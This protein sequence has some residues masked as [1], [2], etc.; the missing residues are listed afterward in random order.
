[1]ANKGT[2]CVIAAL[3]S[4]MALPTRADPGYYL[5]SVYENEGQASVDFRY[6]T[7]KTPGGGETVWPEIGIGYGVTKRWYTEVYASMIGPHYG[8]VRLSTLNWQ[9]D[10]LLTQGQYPFDLALHTNLILNPGSNAGQ[11]LEFG[12][13]LQTEVGRI[14]INTNLIFERFFNTPAPAPTQ[15]K[16]QWQFKYRF[17]PELQM[18]LQGFGELGTWNDWA[19]ADRQSHRAGP[20]VAGTLFQKGSSA[21]KYDA[22]V[23]LGSTYGRQGVMFS[24]RLQYLF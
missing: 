4:C 3:A 12:P 24:S 17:R 11:S 2:W 5:V 8:N 14:Q 20:M 22:A 18:G 23:L 7:V 10:Y 15:L 6:W 19:T 9:N 16:Y 1:M 13:A 21:V